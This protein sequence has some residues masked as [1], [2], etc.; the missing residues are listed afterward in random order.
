MPDKFNDFQALFHRDILALT[1][2]TNRFSTIEKSNRLPD[3][4]NDFQALLVF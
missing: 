1:H 2:V 3:R 4:L